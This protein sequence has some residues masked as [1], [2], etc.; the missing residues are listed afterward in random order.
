MLKEE[1][2]QF[3]KVSEMYHPGNVLT[4]LQSFQMRTD[5]L[6]PDQ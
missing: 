5:P 4:R 3:N 1:R 6:R 2:C